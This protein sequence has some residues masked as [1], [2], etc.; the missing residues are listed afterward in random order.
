[1]KRFMQKPLLT[2]SA[3]SVLIIAGAQAAS[4]N[5]LMRLGIV[6]SNSSTKEVVI[7]NHDQTKC[8]ATHGQKSGRS[9]SL[10]YATCR[11]D[12]TDTWV[13]TNAGKIKNKHSG[14]CLS[15]PTGEDSLVLVH[16]NFVHIRDYIAHDFII[17]DHIVDVDRG[18]A[19][20]ADNR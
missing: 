18:G 1:M 7:F 12:D 9:K 8:L 15:T 3:I 6:K 17:L 16:C 14:K 20:I 5:K 2:L 13:I 4:F 10:I 11:M 19:K